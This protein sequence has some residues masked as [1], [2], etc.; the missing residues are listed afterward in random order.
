MTAALGRWATLGR[1]LFGA[2]LLAFGVQ[3]LLWGDLVVGRA[4]AWPEGMPGRLAFAYVSGAGLVLAGAAVLR[5]RRARE[6][7]LTVAALVFVCALLRHVP[8]ALADRIYGGAWTN[9]GKA[10]A[11]T[12][13][14][15]AVAGFVNVGRVCLG[16]FLFSSGVQH[17]LFPGFVATLVPTWI[18]GPL[19]WTYFA[20]VALMAAGLGLTIPKTAP[21]A[22][23][24]TG[25][26]ILSWV[27]LLHVPR[28]LGSQAEQRQNEW[29]AV[30][31]A[32]AF[33]G[34]AFVLA[35][36]AARTK[37]TVTPRK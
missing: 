28:A 21:W 16:A 1:A 30:V 33:G 11:L 36:G 2:A 35:A 37:E 7:A 31:E 27:V 24:L 29:T 34:L 6:A 10:L 13:G 9:L 18:P 14:A 26:M 12:G 32:I 23:T 3:Q 17:F 25:F 4:P 5:G 19:F 15:L 8:L 20:G 22:G